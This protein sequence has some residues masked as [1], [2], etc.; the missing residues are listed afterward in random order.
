[1]VRATNPDFTQVVQNVSAKEAPYVAIMI[2]EAHDRGDITN[3]HFC[4]MVDILSAKTKAPKAKTPKIPKV[5]IKDTPDFTNIVQNATRT[6]LISVID[7]LEKAHDRGYITNTH[8]V[9]MVRILTTKFH[10]V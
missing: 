6:D 5:N 9:D 10:D 1:M 4:D 8:Y 2:K 7:M 3:T